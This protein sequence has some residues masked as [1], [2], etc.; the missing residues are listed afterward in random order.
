V[1]GLYPFHLQ[2]GRHLAA[3]ALTIR[4]ASHIHLSLVARQQRNFDA[5]FPPP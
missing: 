4:T 5:I 3:L 2:L 1:F